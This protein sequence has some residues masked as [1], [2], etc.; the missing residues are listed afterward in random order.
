MQTHPPFFSTPV[1]AHMRTCDCYHVVSSVYQQIKQQNNECKFL[2]YQF[3]VYWICFISWYEIHGQWT[4]PQPLIFF[5]CRTQLISAK[6]KY[7][8]LKETKNLRTI[9]RKD[10]DFAGFIPTFPPP[11]LLFLSCSINCFRK[12]S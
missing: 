2:P 9:F 3:S 7:L 4:L 8:C 12:P 1:R 11:P 10:S 5:R 6:I